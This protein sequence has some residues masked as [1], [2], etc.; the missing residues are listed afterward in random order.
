MDYKSMTKVQE[1]CKSP[2]TSLGYH[3]FVSEKE[4]NNQS[5]SALTP[6]WMSP[7]MHYNEFVQTVAN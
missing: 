7:L 3:L 2:M 6:N 5:I 4:Y 1:N